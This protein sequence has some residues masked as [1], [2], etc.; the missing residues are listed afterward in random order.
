[1]KGIGPDGRPLD[2]EPDPFVGYDMSS[3]SGAICRI[4]GALVARMPDYAVLHREW[5]ERQ[6]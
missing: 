6:A 5:H 2:D 3:S 4:C 1:V